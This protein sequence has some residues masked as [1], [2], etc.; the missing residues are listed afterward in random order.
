MTEMRR[1][2]NQVPLGRE[3]L[4]A[5][6]LLALLVFSGCRGDSEDLQGKTEEQSPQAQLANAMATLREDR[7]TVTGYRNA[8]QQLNTYLAQNKEVTDKLQL[9]PEEMRLV[10]DVLLADLLSADQTAGLREVERK[11]FTLFDAYHLDACFLFRD[12]A[13]ALKDDL[14]DAPRLESLPSLD[15]LL[16]G[17]DPT[18]YLD[19]AIQHYQDA[20]YKLRLARH[21]FDWVMRQV[22]YQVSQKNLVQTP[23]GVRYVDWPAQDVLRL[24]EGE[25][26][27][28]A[29]VFLAVLEQLGLAGCMVT[30]TVAAGDGGQPQPTE[31]L[32]ET[33]VSS[34]KSVA[35]V[36]GVLVGNDIYLFEPR[37]GTQLMHA[38]GEGALTLRQLREEAKALQPEEQKEAREKFNQW[39]EQIYQAS[40]LTPP[41]K[42]A[43]LVNPE[44]WVPSNLSAVSPRMRELQGWLEKHNNR[45]MLHQDLA[46]SLQR[47]RDAGFKEARLWTRRD[48]PGYPATVSLTFVQVQ[49]QLERTQGSGFLQANVIPRQ[50][51]IPQWVHELA[52]DLTPGRSQRLFN[53]FDQFFIRLRLEPGS[54]RDL[55]VRGR[56]EQAV[57][58][59]LELESRLDRSMDMILT[60]GNPTPELRAAWSRNLR[61]AEEEFRAKELQRRNARAAG[62][63]AREAELRQELNPIGFRIEGLWREKQSAID[64]LA[65]V[66]A[67]PD[68]REHLTYFMGLAKMELAIRAELQPARPRDAL[69]G[70]EAPVQPISAAQ[71]WA[72]AIEWFNRYEAIALSR[73]QAS[74]DPSLQ[75]HL[76]YRAVE[77]HL[78]TCRQ[79]LDRLNKNVAREPS[80][81]RP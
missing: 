45:A 34:R 39:L 19:A 25:E 69:P 40:P 15:D 70:S 10:R 58:R 23:Q 51:L 55:L 78:T 22:H 66:W 67:E 21:T 32:V 74:S 73:I 79:A 60:Q 28:R 20:E 48:R 31:P 3:R 4:P 13:K 42:S 65:L 72:S 56:P 6:L 35:W 76:W 53:R 62:N 43:Q 7:P 59:I 63:T 44:V 61:D 47:F 26:E 18:R 12:A 36:A 41:V 33:K 77:R 16:T 24:G 64:N 11:S 17:H 68:Y 71:H 2:S 81:S 80:E 38:K 30:R 5:L 27:E 29:R 8:V 1:D 46:T 9:P 37:I 57:R 52:H 49:K 54:V 75:D 14:G 50:R